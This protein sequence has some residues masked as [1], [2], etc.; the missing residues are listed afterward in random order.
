MDK[1]QTIIIIVIL[2]TITSAARFAIDSF[3]PSLP[4]I[5]QALH[6]S[7]NAIQLTLTLYMLGFGLSQ[8]M[9]G[10]LSDYVGRK[11]ALIGGIV[12]FLVANTLC[13]FTQSF[14]FLL[15]G[16]FIAGVGMGA[17]GTLNRAVAS[18]CFTGPAFS[19][20]WSY[21]TSTLV[22]VLALAPFIG[23]LVQHWLGWEANFFLASMYV[24]A[25]LLLVLS[26]LPET[27]I[28]HR[29]AV[30]NIQKII[31][32]YTIICKTP[33]FLK[34]SL[35]YTLA[36]AG[37]IAYFQTSSL[38]LMGVFHVSALTYGWCSILIAACYLIGGQIVTRLAFKI[39]STVLLTTGIL[40]LIISGIIMA[41]W[42]WVAHPSISSI[43]V[44]V[45]LFVIGARIIIPNAVSGAFT[46]LRHLGGSTSGMLGCLQMLGT[47]IVSLII[48]RFNYHSPFLLAT[49][50]I[51]LGGISL[52]TLY[53]QGLLQFYRNCVNK[54]P[55][56]QTSQ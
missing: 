47:A 50:F 4:A 32:D 13:A 20:A 31:Q 39:S 3:T 56:L 28:E 51:T 52:I 25:I 27:N 12:L 1:K 22:A 18:D 8:L 36:F 9:Y 38:L 5:S 26:K 29:A 54:L 34:S 46:H 2:C 40:L 42:N 10:P 43:L 17:C 23:S 19:K 35:Y 21:T 11:P 55:M 7:G 44:P 30:F 45:C 49:V 33:S 53:S 16:R 37:L 24:G 48:S 15:V 14:W 41:C 6:V